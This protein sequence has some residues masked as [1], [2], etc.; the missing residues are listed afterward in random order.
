MLGSVAPWP[1]RVV[2]RGHEIVSQK[3]RSLRIDGDAIWAA[4]DVDFAD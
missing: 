4:A 2:G 1:R 3:L